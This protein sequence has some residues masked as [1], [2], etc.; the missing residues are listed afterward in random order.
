M[1][2]YFGVQHAS[3]VAAVSH[4]ALKLLCTKYVENFYSAHI[5]TGE[6]GHRALGNV[7]INIFKPIKLE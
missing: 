7:F 2:G 4:V 5:A 3:F 6:F 1:M